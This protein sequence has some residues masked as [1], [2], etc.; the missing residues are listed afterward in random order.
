MKRSLVS[1]AALAVALA[2]ATPLSAA[3]ISGKIERLSSED[4][5]I[6]LV[7]GPT[8]YL[9]EGA[10]LKGLKPGQTVTITYEMQA[11]IHTAMKIT[12]AK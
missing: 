5:V 10:S 2:V 9:A 11:D 1:A 3:E 8:F 12:P 7:N 6:K 4:D